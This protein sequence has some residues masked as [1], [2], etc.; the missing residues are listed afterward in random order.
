M[1]LP[2]GKVRKYP[3][4]DDGATIQ[5]INIPPGQYGMF[6][7]H[8]KLS[9]AAATFTHRGNNISFFPES[10]AAHNFW[11]ILAQSENLYGIEF[12]TMDPDTRRG[13]N[14]KIRSLKDAITPD[15]EPWRE[16]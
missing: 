11:T 3:R 6:N 1:H 8:A 10:L 12:I 14:A 15:Q 9:G 2:T 13:Y 5:I 4:K 16:M 7:I